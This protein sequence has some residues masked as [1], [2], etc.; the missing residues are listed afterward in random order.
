ML[1]GPSG[2]GKSTLPSIIAGL[3]GTDIGHDSYSE[4][5][6]ERPGTEERDIAMVFQSYA[7]YPAMNVAPNMGFSL[8]SGVPNARREEAR[9]EV[10]KL[11]IERL[12]DR[13]PSAAVGRP[14]PARRHRPRAGARPARSLDEPLSNLDAKLRSRCDRDQKA[15]SALAPPSSTSPTTRSRRLPWRPAS[16]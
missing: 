10:A 8:K 7:L 13:K 14:A 3:G 16:Q 2:C 11:Q 4:R 1:V 9:R 15:I 6:V 12:L 5:R